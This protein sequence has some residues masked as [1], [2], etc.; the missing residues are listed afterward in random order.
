MY[1]PKMQALI[2]YLSEM[3]A[4]AISREAF[5]SQFKL[6]IIVAHPSFLYNDIL[7]PLGLEELRW[8]LLMILINCPLYWYQPEVFILQLHFLAADMHTLPG[9]AIS[10]HLNGRAMPAQLRYHWCNW[11]DRVYILVSDLPLPYVKRVSSIKYT[12]RSIRPR[13]K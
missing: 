5:L 13:L 11:C 7:T 4:T 3:N 6:I 12:W 8:W 10:C 9:P 1:Q 2:I